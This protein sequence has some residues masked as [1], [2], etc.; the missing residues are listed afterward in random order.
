MTAWSGA[1]AA[2]Q[3]SELTG[4]S[5][6]TVAIEQVIKAFG[7][8][9][10]LRGVSLK[11]GVHE[12]VTITGPS[13]SGKSTL[14]N[15]IGSLERPD[16]GRVLVDSRSVPE[17]REAVEFRRHVVGFVF[18]DNLLLP[19][20]SAY[21]NIEAALLASGVRRHERRQQAL[22][23]LSEVGLSHRARH[24]PSQLSGGERQGVALARALANDP[25]LL[26]A[27]EPT[28]ALDS[29]SGERALDLLGAI[30]ARRGMTVIVVSH[31]PEVA[32]RADRVVQLVDGRV[33]RE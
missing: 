8:T 29:A 15:L 4:A 6:A 1:P 3:Q 22:D 19:Y 31:D 24:L 12:W 30:R 16:A 23:R 7:Q 33:Q 20:L 2:G 14:L 28:G 26:L 25:R 5:G 9:Q 13:G 21:G 27:D 18:Q 11:V 32:R 10:A 17:P